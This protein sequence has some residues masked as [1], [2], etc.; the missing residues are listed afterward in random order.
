MHMACPCISS[1]ANEHR[2]GCEPS[3]R[4]L[5]QSPGEEGPFPQ[6]GTVPLW[7]RSPEHPLV[8][9][10]HPGEAGGLLCLAGLSASP[11]SLCCTSLWSSVTAEPRSKAGWCW[12][13]KKRGHSLANAYL[14]AGIVHPE[15]EKLSAALIV[16]L[17]RRVKGENTAWAI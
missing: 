14:F 3:P 4:I 2:W 11:P 8:T 15:L 13:G 17:V 10:A 12:R 16:G 7:E 9:N 5:P 1:I 6:G